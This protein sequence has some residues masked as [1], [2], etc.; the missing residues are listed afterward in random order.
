MKKNHSLA[1]M[2]AAVLL[3]TGLI[4]AGA[5]QRVDKWVQDTLFQRPGAASTEIVI[6]GIDEK[7]LQELGPWPWSREVMGDA[8]LALA[9]D[10]DHLPAVVALD[11]LYAGDSADPAADAYLAKAASLLP[12]VVTASMAEFGVAITWE[13]SRARAM[14]GAAVLE[15]VVPFEALRRNTVQ[16]HINAMLDRD[17]VLRHALLRVDVAPDQRVYSMAWETARLYM[18]SLGKEIQPPPVNAGGH[19]YVPFTGRGGAYDDGVS[20]SDLV[21]GRVPSAFWENKIV[22]I[23][24]YA[25]GL[26]DAYFTSIDKAAPMYGVEYQANVIESLITGNH[27]RE[28]ADWPQLLCLLALSV[29][30]AMGYLRMKVGEGGGLCV[31]MVLLGFG[32]AWVLYPLGLVTHP[33]WLPAAALILYVVSLALHYVTAARERQALALKE[34]RLNAELSLATRIQANALP[35]VFP[36]FPDRNEFDLFA[37]MTPAKEVGGDLYDFFLIDADHLCLVIGDVSGKGVPASL[38]MMV[39]LSLIH[40]V[41]MRNS[42]PAEILRTVN[43]EICARNPEE[44]FVTVWLGVLEISTGKLTAAN[45][46]HE[47]PAV[48]KADGS[49]ELYKDRHGMVIGGLEESRYRE[50]T[51]QMAPGDQ[52][53]VYT[54]GVPEAS[55]A[56]E[57]MFGTDRMIEALRGAAGGG[58]QQLLSAVAEA[59]KAFAGGAPQFDDLTML[60][61]EYRGGGAAPAEEH[62]EENEER[63]HGGE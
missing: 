61:L 14:N 22:L 56:Q 13:E 55:D 60:C 6:I 39:A 24:P 19:F 41:A 23:G 53:F 17:G 32:A 52:L 35:K 37:S 25:V 46:G 48:K 49:F 63:E 12:R 18:E 26:G 40:Y 51:L 1:V 5:L 44:M 29:F 9:A 2:L 10:R 58:P 28:V 36:P 42:S 21:F 62:A 33:L 15:Y 38:F 57:Q 45:A 3:L 43:E 4:G 34:E 30:C 54:D 11:V 16:G 7:S 8:L 59:V 31:F 50:Y 20:V 47:Y 27:K